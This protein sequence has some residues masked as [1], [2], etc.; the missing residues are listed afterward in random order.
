MT[1]VTIPRSYRQKFELDAA[2]E[3]FSGTFR[4]LLDRRIDDECEGHHGDLFLAP[5][6]EAVG[7]VCDPPRRFPRVRRGERTPLPSWFRNAVLMRDDYTCKTCFQQGGR[8][9]V[10]HLIPWSSGGPD[11]SWNLRILCH[12]CNQE[13]SNFRSHGWDYSVRPIVLNC[14]ECDGRARRVAE[15]DWGEWAEAY[16]DGDDGDMAFCVQCVEYSWATFRQ[17]DADPCNRFEQGAVA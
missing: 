2:R 4:E 9:E 14:V 7:H 12:A 1:T 6:L 11:S 10:D 16:H 17:I 15:E 5:M 8:L 3:E 13:R